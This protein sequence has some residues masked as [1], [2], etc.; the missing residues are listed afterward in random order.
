MRY[1]RVTSVST[2]NWMGQDGQWW[3]MGCAIRHLWAMVSWQHFT[4]RRCSFAITRSLWSKLDYT[5]WVGRRPTSIRARK[6]LRATPNNEQSRT[7]WHVKIFLQDALRLTSS[8]AWIAYELTSGVQQA[9]NRLHHIMSGRGNCKSPP[10]HNPDLVRR[11]VHVSCPEKLGRMIGCSRARAKGGL[12]SI[13]SNI[14][15]CWNS[16]AAPHMPN[17]QHVRQLHPALYDELHACRHLRND[18]SDPVAQPDQGRDQSDCGSRDAP[19]GSAVLPHR[20]VEGS[21]V[22]GQQDARRARGSANDCVKLA[23]VIGA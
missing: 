17:V 14:D 23:L 18:E 1:D 4:M 7:T 22:R 9:R 3:L 21:R 20:W 19:F 12:Q 11:V 13:R 5:A 8:D 10:C 15:I 2:F 16:P 6:S